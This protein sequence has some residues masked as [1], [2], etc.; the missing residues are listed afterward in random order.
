MASPAMADMFSLQKSLRALGYLRAGIDGNFGTQTLNAVR[1]LQYDLLWNDGRST[2]GDGNAPVA[3]KDY[4]KGRV[5]A[6]TGTVDAGLQACIADMIAD[7]AFPSLAPCDDPISANSAAISAVAAMNPSPVPVPFLVAILK[8]ESGG[9]HYHVPHGNDV[10]S[11]VVI[12]LDRNNTSSHDAI[13]SRGYGIGQYT[14]FHHPPTAAEVAN[15]IADP[16]KN[17]QQGVDELEGKFEKFILGP[18]DTASDRIAEAGTVPLRRCKYATTDPLYMTDC[19]TCLSA[20][21][22]IDIKAGMT[23]VFAG[24]N[25]TYQQTQYHVGS[26]DG[27]PKRS[28]IPCDWPYAV[29]RYNGSG[30]NSYDYQAEVLLKVLNG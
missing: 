29:R 25:M 6:V 8:Q 22:K 1:A 2:G 14:L 15:V 20:A 5:A 16:V 7:P 24:A 30:P 21:D 27:V 28:A 18:A 13:T 9:M 3:V 10:D 4:N 23:P 17:V 11:Y 26:Y 12:G 19:K